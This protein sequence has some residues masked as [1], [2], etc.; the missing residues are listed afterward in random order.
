MREAAEKGNCEQQLVSDAVGST[1]CLGSFHRASGATG[2][3]VGARLGPHLLES[4]A[5]L[6]AM[7][8]LIA[9][10][11]LIEQ[12]SWRLRFEGQDVMEISITGT[13]DSEK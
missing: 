5:K 4:V 12:K 10:Q 7:N 3:S 9:E 11:S 1:L 2:F 6:R 13:F 8:L